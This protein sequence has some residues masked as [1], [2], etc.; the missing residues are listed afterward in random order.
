MQGDINKQM[1]RGIDDSSVLVVFVTSRYVTKVNGEG[2]N[3][4]N[5]NCAPRLRHAASLSSCK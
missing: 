5:D 4:A 2:P 1:T 3:G